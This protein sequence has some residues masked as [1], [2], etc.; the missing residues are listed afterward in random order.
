M[1]WSDHARSPFA[2]RFAKASID[3]VWGFRGIDAELSLRRGEDDELAGD[4]DRDSAAAAARGDGVRGE[5]G[6][7]GRI[8]RRQARQRTD[9]VDGVEHNSPA[10]DESTRRR[11]PR[12]RGRLRQGPEE[13]A[14]GVHYGNGDL[15]IDGELHADQPELLIYEQRDGSLRLVGVEFLV[16]VDAWNEAGNPAP[17]VL[18]GQQ[19]HLVNSPNRY[20]IP[21][22]YEL[23]V[24]AWKNNPHGTFVDWNPTVSCSDYAGEP[25]SHHP[26]THDGD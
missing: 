1:L 10:V 26:S 9:P 12:L 21:A 19:F 6:G 8:T 15:V 7:S 23:H 18:S 5:L 20:G 13:G 25:A 16:F 3:G 22:F 14:M 11:G 2:A 4:E 17:P 24:W